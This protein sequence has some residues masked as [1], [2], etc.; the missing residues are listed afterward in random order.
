MV[1]AWA[2]RPDLI[3]NEVGCIFLESEEPSVVRQPPLFLCASELVHSKKD[4]L[5]HRAFIQVLEVHDFTTPEDSDSDGRS[6]SSDSSNSSGDA[7][8][9][10][11]HGSLRPWT[12]VHRFMSGSTPEGDS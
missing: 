5:Q 8:F 3:P 7:E 4:T 11:G 9:V 1:V 12:T 10:L 6:S 2:I